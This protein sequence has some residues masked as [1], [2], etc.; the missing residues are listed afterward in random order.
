[1][2]GSFGMS[3]VSKKGESKTVFHF[4]LR[5]IQGQGYEMDKQIFKTVDDFINEVQQSYG[6]KEVLECDNNPLIAENYSP[7]EDKLSRKS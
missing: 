2:Q 3:C 7:Y 5:Y 1:M 4:R 6:L